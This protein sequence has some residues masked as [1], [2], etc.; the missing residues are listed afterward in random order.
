MQRDHAAALRA[1]PRCL[2]SFQES[3]DA[4]QL[5]LGCVI[6]QADLVPLAITPVQ[7]FDQRAGERRAVAAMIYL[8]V[9][10]ARLDVAGSTV[11]RLTVIWSSASVTGPPGAQVDV[12]H[13]AVHPAG[14]QQVGGKIIGHAHEL[15]T[16]RFQTPA[17]FLTRPFVM[18]AGSRGK[19]GPQ[20]G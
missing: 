8:V 3:R 15:L 18:A 13:Q 16:S 17:D 20:R 11:V 6:D 2:L 12:T 19:V 10:R 1:R 5:E 4:Q 9:V 14:S 7:A